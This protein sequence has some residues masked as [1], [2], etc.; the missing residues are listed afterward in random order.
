MRLDFTL[1]IPEQY[2]KVL[3]K[4]LTTLN[5][6]WSGLPPTGL[7][8]SQA[9]TLIPVTVTEL[10]LGGNNLGILGGTELA[11][12][13]QSIPAHVTVVRLGGCTLGRLS[14]PELVKVFKAIPLSVTRLD[15]YANNLFTRAG[16]ELSLLFEALPISLTVL[17][18]SGNELGINIEHR[19]D[20]ALAFAALPGG[21][22]SLA[23]FSNALGGYTSHELIHAFMALKCGVKTLDLRF[24]K[25][26]TVAELELVF[27]AISF[28]VTTLDISKNKL[29]SK[30]ADEWT[31]ILSKTPNTLTHIIGDK[32]NQ[33]IINQTLTLRML[34]EF[35]LP[36]GLA[37]LVMSYTE[38]CFFGAGIKI[39]KAITSHKDG[40]EDDESL[41]LV[42][43]S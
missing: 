17:D 33:R 2:A 29:S 20:L 9:F 4:D 21:I 42:P 13:F 14:H 3:S 41:P 7:Q 43:W 36:K 12:A 31:K 26:D 38:D 40:V 19:P 11:R 22:T 37:H 10:N 23:L 24:N 30:T 39:S 5:I 16:V 35:S 34:R 8:L 15:L 27:G 32:D 6:L 18:I 1:S 28:S 25:L